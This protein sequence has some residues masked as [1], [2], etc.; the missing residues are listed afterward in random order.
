MSDEILGMDEQKPAATDSEAAKPMGGTAAGA[1]AGP[2][3]AVGS[4]M[5][6]SVEPSAEPSVEPKI[7][8]S[9]TD[10]PEGFKLAESEEGRLSDAFAAAAEE[11]ASRPAGE[12]A[13]RACLR[14]LHAKK[15]FMLPFGAEAK[16]ALS[17]ALNLHFGPSAPKEGTPEEYFE[18]TDPLILSGFGEVLPRPVAMAVPASPAKRKPAAKKKPSPKKA[19]IEAEDAVS[20]EAEAAADAEEGVEKASSSAR[21]AAKKRVAATKA[22]TKK[23]PGA[24]K[25]PANTPAKKSARKTTG[26]PSSEASMRPQDEAS[27][28]RRPGAPEGWTP[29]T[30]E[31]PEAG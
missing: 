13:A 19:G 2:A 25:T 18:A 12:L 4:S 15:L 1:S 26:T 23:K 17:N 29:P 10:V 3:D 16:S 24:K 5:D 11:I 8:S 27:D 6:S 14:W 22:S 30:Q 9:R 20:P 31:E 7:L 28:W 21:A